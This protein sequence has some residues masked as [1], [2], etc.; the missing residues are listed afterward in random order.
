MDRWPR[1]GDT[2]KAWLV[3]YLLFR[4]AIEEIKTQPFPYVGLSGIQVV[5]LG[6]LLYYVVVV[7]RR[8][9]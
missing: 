1:D 2:F 5:C 8:W 9:A 4:L 7:G 6:G 3:G